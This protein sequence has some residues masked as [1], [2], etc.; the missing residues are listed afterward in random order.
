MSM[1]DTAEY[2]LGALAEAMTSALREEEKTA[3]WREPAYR[4]GFSN[5]LATIAV[6][7]GL[8]TQVTYTYPC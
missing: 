4:K 7:M 5:A 2:Q 6:S 1:A 3:Q 8:T